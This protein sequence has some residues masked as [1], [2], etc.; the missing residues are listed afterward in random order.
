MTSGNLTWWP[1]TG[2]TTFGPAI[3][4][5]LPISLGTLSDLDGDGFL[6]YVR[7]I[8][9]TATWYQGLGGGAFATTPQTIY[10]GHIDENGLFA[11]L[12]LD[13][14]KEILFRVYIGT[15]QQ[16]HL[17]LL[18]NTADISTPVREQKRTAFSAVP[19][20]FTDHTVLRSGGALT[21]Q[22][23]VQLCDVQ[24]RALRTLK[25]NNEGQVLIDRGSLSAGLY[26]VR[27]LSA[28]GAVQETLRL[29]AE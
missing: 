15:R 8:T 2:P 19:N 13:G 16:P 26:L 28:T 5:P 23:V 6:D 22:H 12:D 18:E 4:N 1:R 11:D 29:V 20:P 17:L 24:G 25:S 27:V 14:D 9:S 7:V 3:A 21:P 10:T